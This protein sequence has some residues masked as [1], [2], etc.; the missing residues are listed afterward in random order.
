MSRDGFRIVAA[1]VALVG[2]AAGQ[3]AADDL[4]PA[5][6]I[7]AALTRG[8]VVRPRLDA[9]GYTT[10]ETSAHVSLQSILFDLD[11][12][13]LRDSSTRQLDEVAAALKRVATRGPVVRPKRVDEDADV[14]GAAPY[15]VLIEG[16][17]CDRGTSEY[18][19]GLSKRR[20]ERVREYLVA[21]G[22]EAG[23][24]EVRAWGEERPVAANTD[25]ASRRR[26]RRVDF[27]LR[28]HRDAL[29]ETTRALIDSGEGAG[30]LLDVTFEAI[31]LSQGG[32]RYADGEIGVLE[33]GDRFRAG[34]RV[35][36]GCHVY[37]LFLAS[38]GRVEWLLPADGV[39]DA[40]QGIWC[41][42]GDEHSL[43]ENGEYYFL[44]EHTGKE[45]LC[46]VPS[47]APIERASELPTVLREQAADVSTEGLREALSAQDIE[48]HVL[49]IDHR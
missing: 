9:Q 19:R 16:H 14:P 10:A 4:M 47:P 17:T 3:L 37:S 11:S 43:P 28:R 38:D 36:E 35:L 34:F 21:K 41:Y 25:E 18:N 23:M 42:A 20:A 12:D 1:T 30:G 13:R 40:P 46:L 15:R 7:E 39:D 8:P 48:A 31:A 27:V 24:F 5:Q 49:V 44:D 22:V 26:N 2:A 6:D 33:S 32:K 29:E 45:V